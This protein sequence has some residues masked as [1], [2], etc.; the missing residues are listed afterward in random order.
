MTVDGIKMEDHFVF[1]ARRQTRVTVL[2]S[3]YA[4][5]SFG[6]LKSDCSKKVDTLKTHF[7]KKRIVFYFR[8]IKFHQNLERGGDYSPRGSG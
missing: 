5:V 3:A 4:R 8:K 6:R 2:Q 7:C 1:F